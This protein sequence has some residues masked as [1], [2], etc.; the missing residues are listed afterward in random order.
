MPD[1]PRCRPQACRPQARRPQARRRTPRRTGGFTL[2]ELLIVV[3]IVAVLLGILLPSL[4]RATEMA[5]RV[6]C[7]SNLRQVG[8]AMIAYAADH[9][10]TLAYSNWE[11]NGVSTPAPAFP[12]APVGWLYRSPP[13][14]SAAPDPAV[15]ET[16][17]LW[18]YLKTRD[19]YRCPGHPI[20]DAGGFGQAKSDRLTSY[21]VNGAINLYGGPGGFA[22]YFTIPRFQPDDVLLWEANE[23]GGYGWNDGASYPGESLNPG[24]PYPS[25][26]TVRHGRAASVVCMD[27]R[28]ELMS[29]EEYRTLSADPKRNRLWCA[30]DRANGR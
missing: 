28:A 13:G 15:V 8:Q 29:H 4:G 9:R 7:V 20:D 24:D 2:V 18:K 17:A 14:L 12:N 30:P 5:R 25:G 27:G 3:A 22:R 6:R 16:G 19:V 11:P 21:L 1:D 23:R 26:L 10:Q